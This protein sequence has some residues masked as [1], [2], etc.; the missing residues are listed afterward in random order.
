MV[1]MDLAKA[2]K[3][4]PYAR[5]VSTLG[6]R[7]LS[8]LL[9]CLALGEACVSAND[10][11][12]QAKDNYEIWIRIDTIQRNALPR[13]SPSDQSRPP[14]IP[15][16]FFHR[17]RDSTANTGEQASTHT[18]RRRK[19]EDVD[20]RLGSIMAGAN[21][22]SGNGGGSKMKEATGAKKPAVRCSDVIPPLLHC[23]A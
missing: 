6:K 17:A 5:I 12:N 11:A 18:G 13:P 2:S 10:N 9:S 23:V 21:S 1:W 19:R 15:P 7:A 16:Q 22:I 20:E 14:K 4:Q 3:L 8:Y